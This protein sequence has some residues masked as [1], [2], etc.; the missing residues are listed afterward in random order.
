MKLNFITKGIP[1]DQPNIFIGIKKRKIC[2]PFK[3]ILLLLLS[4]T[5]LQL[6]AFERFSIIKKINF[7][8]N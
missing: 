2:W 8:T 7:V 5:N 3:K 1:K 4:I 6:W